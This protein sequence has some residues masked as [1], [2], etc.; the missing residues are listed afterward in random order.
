MG[1]RAGAGPGTGMTGRVAAFLGP[2]RPME[3]QEYAVP[4]PEPGALVVRTAVA[5]VCGTDLHQWR[6]EFDIA[7]FGRPYPQVLGH[8]MTGVVHALGDGVAQDSSGTPLA[9][10]DRV[11]FR[12]FSPCGHCPACL[13]GASRAC[14]DARTYLRRPCTDAP[15]FN[16]AFGDFYYVRPGTSVF[17]VPDGLPDAVVAG[18]NCALSQVVAGLEQCGVLLGESV[19]IQG[20]GG[21]GLYATA[22]AKE[23]GAGQV[24][25]VDAIDERLELARRF[26]ADHTV[27]LSETPETDDRLRLIHG[28]TDDWGGDV[29]VD[30]AGHP[31]AFAEG[32]GML[33]RTGRYLEIG[34]LTPG[35]RV[36]ID[37]SD[38]VFR[39]ATIHASFYYEASHLGRALD[40][41]SRRQHDYP[42][43]AVA[44][45][46]FALED[47]NEAFAAADR[48]DVARAS[49][50]P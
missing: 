24:I 35:T 28:L 27:S 2:G 5:N 42:W 46:P 32:I 14:P 33:S 47:V 45:E 25:V 16:G 23:M 3:I 26:G 10:G 11:V 43:D 40:L 8:E 36:G 1:L 9:V 19:V 49:I 34:S 48:G 41:L 50:M 20:A 37:V 30:V 22:V 12:Y 31:S 13:K 6:G 18:V 15:H 29:V 39:N 4:E 7:R 21:L 17:R 38:L 44:S